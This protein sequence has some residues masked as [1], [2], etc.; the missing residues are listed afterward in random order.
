MP[1]LRV[2]SPM[3]PAVGGQ[4]EVDVEGANVGEVLRHL[5]ATYPQVRDRLLTPEGG[6]QP[7]LM[8]VVDG[9]EATGLFTPVR[10][11]S[12]ILIVPSIGGGCR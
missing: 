7:H 6:L 8:I 2:P 5:A 11:D 4:Q 1:R 3:R 12:E 10:P 9:V